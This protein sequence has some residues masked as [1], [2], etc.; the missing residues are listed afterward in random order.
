MR[1]AGTLLIACGV[2]LL[3]SVGL[4]FIGALLSG[5]SFRAH[6]NVVV[7]FW[8]AIFGA[9]ALAAGLVLKRIAR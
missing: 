5:H 7:Q 3:G 1:A 4:S 8:L 9:G 2:L 6:T